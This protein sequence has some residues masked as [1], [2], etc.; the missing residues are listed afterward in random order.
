MCGLGEFLLQSGLCNFGSGFAIFWTMQKVNLEKRVCVNI[1][2]SREA[3]C[4]FRSLLMLAILEYLI[5][6]VGCIYF[7][8]VQKLMQPTSLK[9]SCFRYVLKVTIS[10]GY[11]GTITQYQDFV[12]TYQ[13]HSFIH[14]KRTWTLSSYTPSKFKCRAVC[15]SF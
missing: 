2:E 14:N 13:L 7:L 5:T 6:S 8:W 15:I 1:F 10:R 4:L 3:F 11:A 9:S 12:V